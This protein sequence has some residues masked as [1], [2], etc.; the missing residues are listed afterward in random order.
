MGSV[1]QIAGEIA[2]QGA[3]RGIQANL[4]IAPNPDA[5]IQAARHFSGTTF[6]RIGQE[7]TVLGEIPVT[8]LSFPDEMREALLAWG[9]NTFA[10]FAALPPLGIV[11]R[12]GAE[13]LRLQDQARGIAR[14]PL[15]LRR[16]AVQFQRNARF[17]HPLDNSQSLLFIIN[18]MLV[19]LC[20]E[21]GLHGVAASELRLQLESEKTELPERTLSFAIPLRGTTSILKLLQLHLDANPPGAEV[22]GLAI[23][24]IAVEPRVAQSGLF[25]PTAPEPARLEILL[26]RIGGIVGPENIGAAELLNTHRPDAFLIRPMSCITE[27]RH[28]TLPSTHLVIRLYRPALH[29]RVIVEHGY[30]RRVAAQGITGNVITYGG[31]W[32]G[33]G[34]WWTHATWARDE[35]DVALSDGGVYRIYRTDNEWFVSGV[36]D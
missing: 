6:I 22:T 34:D 32:R 18:G 20:R 31:P 36:Y 4:A 30:P 5:A 7:L 12:F 17:D 13:G 19:D 15:L 33:S 26:A 9:I 27:I 2:K 14:R 35:W 10:E 3:K 1:S 21:M 28:G 23:V 16:G 29:A 8:A 25:A 11:E 24:L